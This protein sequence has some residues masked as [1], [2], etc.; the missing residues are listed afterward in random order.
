MPQNG[1]NFEGRRRHTRRNTCRPSGLMNGQVPDTGLVNGAVVH[2]GF[3]AAATRTSESMPAG[4]PNGTKPQ[5]MVNG[6]INHG[7]KGKNTKALPPRTLE[8]QR[9]TFSAVTDT[10]AAG[11]VGS[12]GTP[13]GILV[14]GAASLDTLP[15]SDQMAPESRLSA[16]VKNQRWRRKFRHQKR[17]ATYLICFE[18]RKC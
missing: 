14:N 8:K 5:C 15:S 2:N 11:R 18:C 16:A 4:T 10:S 7:Y 6:Y 1:M 12:R 13:G 17:C 3:P 9:S